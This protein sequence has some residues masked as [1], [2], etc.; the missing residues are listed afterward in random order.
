M[1]V[2]PHYETLTVLSGIG[3]I[4]MKTL[5]ARNE[6]EPI[7]VLGATTK[8]SNS[9]NRADISAGIPIVMSKNAYRQ[10]E[11]HIK[12]RELIKATVEGIYVDEIPSILDNLPIKIPTGVPC[13]CICVPSGRTISDIHEGD[14]AT[15]A[16]WSI[17]EDMEENYLMAFRRFAATDER[18][19]EEA[20]NFLEDYICRRYRGRP[21]TDFD[22]YMSTLPALFSI[23]DI[24]R[25]QIDERKLQ[26]L[27]LKVRS[28]YP[29]KPS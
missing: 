3:S 19:S 10:I 29:I 6:N 2:H 5:E 17:F 27:I 13:S 1:L 16:G 7:K 22:E 15:A 12:R 8:S 25:G 21:L 4:R 26:D 24:K 20:G 14:D 9:Q 11:D 23:S 28:R 18:G